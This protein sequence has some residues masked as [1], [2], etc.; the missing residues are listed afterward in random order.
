M[1]RLARWT[2]RLY[3][4]RW[5]R[6]YGDEVDALVSDAGADARVVADLLKGAVRMQFAA[7]SFP[8]SRRCWD[9]LECSPASRIHF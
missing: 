1:K 8:G 6:R 5:R 2:M 3:P 4:V 7:W 9:R